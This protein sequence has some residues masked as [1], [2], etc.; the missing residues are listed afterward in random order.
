MLETQSGVE[1]DL[2]I[3]PL[4]GGECPEVRNDDRKE[5]EDENQSLKRKEEEKKRRQSRPRRRKSKRRQR[6]ELK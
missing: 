3:G 5:G 2:P 1:G 4:A 6:R